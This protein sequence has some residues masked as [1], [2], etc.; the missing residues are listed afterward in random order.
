MENMSNQSNDDDDS[1]NAI[2]INLTVPP[3]VEPGVD[4]LT[5]Q[6]DGNEME[7]LIPEDS[8]AGDVLQIQVGSSAAENNSSSQS[9]D[10]GEMATKSSS[11]LI[12]E[13]NGIEDNVG[14]N[15]DT[16]LAQNDNREGIA[17]VTLGEGLKSTI[18]LQLLEELP[19]EHSSSAC[20]RE[21]D[22]TAN[23]LWPSGILLAQS[24]TS[25]MGIEYL[26]K[27]LKHSDN[28]QSVDCMELGSGLGTCGIA[29][30]HACAS[31]DT[32]SK[33]SYKIVLT[34]RGD[35][36][37]ALLQE[38]VDRNCTFGSA[39][40]KI[41]V[42]SHSLSWG[43]E[44]ST[45]FS[46][47]TKFHCIIGSD[48][49][50]NSRESYMPLLH[51]IQQHLHPDGTVILSVRWRKPELE[52]EFFHKA[53]HLGII[54]VNWEEFEECET[55]SDRCPARLNW[56]DYGNPKSEC[57]NEYFLKTNVSVGNTT[58]SLAEI[59]E[60]DMECMNDDEYSSFEEKQI[61]IYV[62]YY[63]EKKGRKRGF[64]GISDHT[65]TT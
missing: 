31:I 10:D 2:Y 63:S 4:S 29:L 9:G 8:V 26:T 65:T 42:T 13:L 36:T 61:Q 62:A 17:T 34:D 57:S 25:K 24:L 46:A 35:E 43:N 45:D 16:K 1:S 28:C 32:S 55:F 18:T 15:N 20:N 51:T 30:A 11:N 19:K 38:N 33:T 22:G 40:K 27:I 49:L 52:R 50:Y 21:G 60:D 54:F 39:N 44:L 64:D 41:S 37:I 59:T 47:P 23:C 48:L 14:V 56:K 12:S 3:N 5:F 6:Y 7:I 58:K 53:E